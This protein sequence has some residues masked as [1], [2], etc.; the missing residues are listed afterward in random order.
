MGLEFSANRTKLTAK[1]DLTLTLPPW[2]STTMYSTVAR[3][4]RGTT[5]E[6]TIQS[7]F[8]RDLSIACSTRSVYPRKWDKSTYIDVL[9]YS[10]MI[11]EQ[12]S[13][14]LSF[15]RVI[16]R[17]RQWKRPRCL[18]PHMRVLSRP[19]LPQ[20]RSCSAWWARTSTM[21]QWMYI[22]YNTV[23]RQLSSTES[24]SPFSLHSTGPIYQKLLI[25]K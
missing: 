23:S 3:R 6:W 4:L 24:I 13:H 21:R 17:H 7:T 20:Q 22:R 16:R 1:V 19:P 8:R 12:K 25:S 10:M 15:L 5:L 9:S 11:V 2:E 18:Q 14:L